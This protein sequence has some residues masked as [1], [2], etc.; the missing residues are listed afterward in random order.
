M[1][2]ISE[3]DIG[4]YMGDLFEAPD[5]VGGDELV[6]E[7]L[8]LIP[9]KFFNECDQ[10]EGIT[11][12][13]KYSSALWFDGVK[14][15]LEHGVDMN[16]EDEN[17]LNAF[18][19]VMKT[20]NN[21]MEEIIV[22]CDSTY[23]LNALNNIKSKPNLDCE[24]IDN[25]M[26]RSDLNLSH[27]KYHPISDDEYLKIIK[28]LANRTFDGKFEAVERIVEL[29]ESHG[30]TYKQNYLVLSLGNTLNMN[31]GRSHFVGEGL[32]NYDSTRYL[33]EKLKYNNVE[34]D[35]LIEDEICGSHNKELVK[36][37]L[38]GDIDW[39]HYYVTILE[40]LE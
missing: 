26:K 15:L 14:I 37:W 2:A 22:G 19:Y 23:T 38:S 35:C 8:P 12:L 13:M 25:I 7:Y 28:N 30:L 3:V 16:I 9:M 17:G 5:L 1:E 40:V 21:M 4:D 36:K 27:G 10:Y 39:K 18:M 6:R 24:I 32:R 33:I 20:Y 29:F 31:D 11:L 34:I